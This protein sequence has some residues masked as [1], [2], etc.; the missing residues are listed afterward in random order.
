MTHSSP[1]STAD[2]LRLAKS[3]PELG[4]ENPWHQAMEPCRMPG[5][6]SFFCSSVPHWRI[7]GPTNVSPKK[8]ARMGV[9]ALANSSFKTTCSMSVES[10]A[11]VLHGPA[12]A[13]PPAG[14]ELLSPGLVE[15]QALFAT[16][17]K[18]RFE[19]A[20]GQVLFEP[21]VNLLAKRLGFSGVVQIHSSKRTQCVNR[22][23]GA[24][25]PSRELGENSRP[26]QF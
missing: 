22:T 7:V 25:V 15:V 8:S 2:V 13:D 4:S 20:R 21:G 24:F 14:E 17:R 26:Q 3:E 10:L 11:A 16:H 12:S 9:L 18:A 23:F 6:N 5:M 1:S 19:P